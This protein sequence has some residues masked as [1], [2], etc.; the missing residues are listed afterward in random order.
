[1]TVKL[2]TEKFKE[3]IFDYT[4]GTEWKYKGILPAIIDFYTD[5]CQPCKL[6]APVFEEL[7]NEYMGKVIFYKANIDDNVML[8]K[9]FQITSI[10]SILFI[11]LGRIP[12][13]AVGAL[14]RVN[15]EEAVK[16]IL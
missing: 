12:E 1:M 7:S 13:M 4:E 2:T 9:E 15:L 11:P 16:R 10:P 8:A 14:P 5:W 6:M 3:L